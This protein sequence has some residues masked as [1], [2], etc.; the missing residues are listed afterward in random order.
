MFMSSMLRSRIS[1]RV[2][3]EEHLSL[4]EIYKTH[5]YQSKP[6]DYIGEIFQRCEAREHFNI[7]ADTVK[8]SHVGALPQREELAGLE[9]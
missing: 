7:V 4:T 5:P 8:K 2:I 6:P 1:R 9:H 3:V